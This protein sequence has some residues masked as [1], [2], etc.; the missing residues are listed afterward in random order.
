MEKQG[1]LRFLTILPVSIL[2][3]VFVPVV[4]SAAYFIYNSYQDAVSRAQQSV[5]LQARTTALET[6]NK[7]STLHYQLLS[8]TQNPVLGEVSVNLLYSQFAANQLQNLV[9]NNDLIA[10]AFIADGSDFIVEGYP[11]EILRIGTTEFNDLIS[12]RLALP[13]AKSEP[14]LLVLDREFLTSTYAGVLNDG[15]NI[16]F[17]LPLMKKNDSI[18]APFKVTAG[19]FVVMD[20][21]QLV[22]SFDRFGD[23]ANRLSLMIDGKPILVSPSIDNK[24]YLTASSNLNFNLS[25]SQ[26]ET[27]QSIDVVLHSPTD[28]FIVQIEQAVIN[29]LIFMLVLAIAILTTLAFFT[30]HFTGPLEHLLAFSRRLAKGDYSQTKYDSNFAEFSELIEHLNGMSSTIIKQLETLEDGKEKAQISEKIKARFLA[31]MSHEIRTPLN[32]ILGLL[33]MLSKEDLEPQHK[34]W[35]LASL[36]TSNLLLNIVNDILDFSKL[37]EGKV[38]IERTLFSV[39]RVVQSVAESHKLQL[40]EKNINCT[41]SYAENMKD[42]WL[43]DPL[44]ISQILMNLV[45]NAVKFTE[46]GGIKIVV[47]VIPRQTHK[48]LQVKIVDTGIGMSNEQLERLFESF[49][50]G[51]ISTTRKYGGTGLGLSIANGLATLMQGR[52]DATSE[53]GVGTTFTFE[54]EVFDTDQQVK[55]LS[56]VVSVPDFSGFNILVAEDNK[57]NQ[58]IIKSILEQTHA[59]IVLV[60][61]GKMAVDAC[62]RDHYD[63]ILMDVQM[64]EMDGLQATIALRKQAFNMPIV[65]QTANVLEDEVKAYLENGANAHI[66]KPIVEIQLFETLSQLLTKQSS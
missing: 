3:F 12:E 4:F 35:V 39:E 20:I 56:P 52:I 49:H 10:G 63:L 59:H 1:K 43:G 44:R 24:D 48:M 13:V 58:L 50:Q 61:D 9:Q 25:S 47:K 33:K 45:S 65:M 57:I 26:L 31:N 8:F 36:S 37:E 60:E 28:K 66:G 54:V 5:E 23:E 17:Y 64:P 41:V 62:N 27:A 34:K 14:Q 6:K 21:K 55:P 22:Q 7:I 51:D 46:T 18:A 16:L 42:N 53:L 29:T 11:T 40:D 30:S 2:L 19:L 38:E 32:G 15:Y